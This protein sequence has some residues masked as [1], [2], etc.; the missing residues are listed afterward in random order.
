MEP[1]RNR[2]HQTSSKFTNMGDMYEHFPVHRQGK[3]SETTGIQANV[4]R[5]CIICKQSVQT[6]CG[7]CN[8]AVCF[9]SNYDDI[10]ENTCW[11]L[12]HNN[13]ENFLK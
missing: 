2:T 10:K 8:V 5:K 11:Y 9:G 6:G 7:K 3:K 1:K 4:R 12:H 13:E